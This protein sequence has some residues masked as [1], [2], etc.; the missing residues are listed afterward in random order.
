MGRRQRSFHLLRGEQ[1]ADCFP[2]RAGRGR[3]RSVS[4]AGQDRLPGPNLCRLSCRSGVLS[5][6]SQ[7]E[8]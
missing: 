3:L 4:S 1:A 2:R 8:L 5:V 6:G 7:L